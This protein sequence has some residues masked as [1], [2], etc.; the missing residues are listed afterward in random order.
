[1]P[2]PLEDWKGE[3]VQNL[4]LIEDITFF[5]TF[6]KDNPENQSITEL[7]Y[8]R[9]GVAKLPRLMFLVDKSAP[10][11]DA[12]KDEVTGEGEGGKRIAAFR[13]EIEREKLVSYFTTPEQLAGLVSVAVQQGLKNRPNVANPFSG[14]AKVDF[15]DNLDSKD[16]P[17]LANYLKI[18][19]RDQRRFEHGDE[20]RGIWEWLEIRRRLRELP[21][22]L[23]AI[24]R[25]D[26]AD[27][28]QWN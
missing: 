20:G 10:W 12:F 6:A 14:K 1:M 9:A 7:E 22:A 19:P 4:C 16:W 11:S 13:A 28:L 27:L 25:E 23:K 3:P 5:G 15:C 8:H 26:L 24:E 18:P 17:R 2:V 21:E